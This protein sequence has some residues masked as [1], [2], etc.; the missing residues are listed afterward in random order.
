MGK[1]LFDQY[2]NSAKEVFDEVDEALGVS[3]QKII[4]EGDQKTLTLT[5]NAQPAILATSIA[6]LRVLQKEYGFDINKAC[7]YVLGH[8]LGEYT[9]LVASESLPLSD[10]VKLVQLRG[11][12]MSQAIQDRSN[13]KG[14]TGML[15]LVGRNGKLEDIEASIQLL[16]K[17]LPANEVVEIANIN[18]TTQI[19]LSGTENG[20]NAASNYLK[21]KRMIA[22]AI[23]LEVSAPFHSSLVKSA[24][25]TM[26]EA[27]E[28]VTFK[29][30]R[31]HVIS[32]VTARPYKTIE[33]I[34]TTLIRQITSTVQWQQS[35]HFCKTQDVSDFVCFGPGTVLSG[36]LKKDYPAD[37]IR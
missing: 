15:A 5:E 35:I 21:E 16:Q 34:P 8:S 11:K 29:Q 25:N 14:K 1:D 4:F 27:F 23:P 19:V 3:L 12:A 9:A 20:L 10:A 26:K 2:P 22:R 33:E 32:N 18:S 30:P 13:N 17:E 36:L 7:E 6:T 28:K 31:V 37:I 24:E